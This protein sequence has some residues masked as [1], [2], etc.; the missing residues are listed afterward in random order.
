MHPAF[1]RS[2]A[3]A[4]VVLLLGV[5]VPG[6]SAADFPV[7]ITGTRIGL[8][9]GVKTPGDDSKPAASI[10][11]FACWNPVYV[12]LE[13]RAPITEAAELFIESPDPDGITTTM[14]VPLNL[15][16]AGGGK[17][18]AADLGTLGYLRP[19]G[20]GEVTIT[21][22]KKNGGAT[23]SDPFRVRNLR[24]RDP[25]TYV[26][27]SLGGPLTGFDLPK[28]AGVAADPSVG[29]RGGRIELATI[30]D[31]AQLPDQWFGYESA[32]VAILHTGTGTEPFLTRL[33][34]DGASAS[35]KAKRVALLEWVRRGGRL[36]V[37]TGQN[38]AL[39][40]Q[41][42]LR[43]LHEVLPY[44]VNPAS[45]SSMSATTDLYWPA[46]EGSNAGTLSASLGTAAGKFPLA[47]L[48]PNPATSARVLIPPPDRRAENRPTV[49]TQCSFGLGKITCVGFDLD[50]PPFT[51]FS[52]RAEF[53]DWVLREGGAARAS[54][55]GDGKPRPPSST[56][57]EDDDELATAV[58][59]HADSFDGVPVVSFGWIALLIVGYILLIGPVEYYILK[60]IFGRLELTWITF[61]IIVAT[62]SLAA[63][64]S[65]YSLKGR[66]LKVNKIDLIDVD[67]A[68]NRVYGSTRFTVF[69]PRIDT[70][71][72]GITPND[73]WATAE[74]GTTVNW[75]GAAR[76]GRATLLRRDYRYHSDA[77]SRA[78]GLE[79]V[80]VQVWSTKSFMA[81]WSARLD[82]ANAIISSQLEHP[83][84]DRSAVVGTFTNRLPVPVLTDCV[85]F[86][87]G[88]A[89]PLPGGT[90][91][92]GE[93]VRLVLDKGTPASQWLQKEGRLEEVLRTVP[94]YA[95][96]P[97]A[98]KIVAAQPGAPGV[99]APTA[100]GTTL[101]LWGLLF[102]ESSLTNAE[103]VVPRNSSL[104][105][106]DQ[107]WRL[108]A[109]HRDEV[110]LV[111]RAT[112]GVGPAEATLNGP[113]SPSKLWI[114]ELPGNDRTPIPGT[115]RQETWV[116]VYLPVK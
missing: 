86:Y 62:V 21:V 52:R 93:T 101:P 69:S 22:R 15:A 18:L 73:G 48:I 106:L 31:I 85:A 87:A 54:A 90:I 113:D 61:P 107:S 92:T 63:Y 20:T 78:D 36:V 103:G 37:A 75:V 26:V 35:D 97:G 74:P 70:Y 5:A 46:R 49:A 71:T 19:A 60:R 34:G 99:L 32:D 39:V 13:L 44:S 66:D 57:S 112:P 45:P 3:V 82:P 80:P 9:T 116:R 105:H 67:P 110:I 51:E 100:I 23:L 42:Q 50:R 24:P 84:G 98:A 83:P 108:N 72:L 115:G 88:Q 40:S 12:E 104:R 7:T 33:F 29:F 68:S 25:L 58:R 16:G 6:V 28:A 2:I 76:G 38:A 64:F 14:T 91:R 79:K 56:V 4:V 111:G 11:R 41:P 89:Y 96:R 30:T 10:A 59:T 65:A 8:P 102:H 94:S 81:N 43:S 47:N 114:K 95:D 55:G 53:W 109:D 1:A 17:V 27:L 77:D